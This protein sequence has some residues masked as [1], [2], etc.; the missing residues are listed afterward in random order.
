VVAWSA[1]SRACEGGGTLPAGK[2]ATVAPGLFHFTSTPIPPPRV[3]R[4]K[5]SIF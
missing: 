4:V 3:T 1:A 2:M 5:V